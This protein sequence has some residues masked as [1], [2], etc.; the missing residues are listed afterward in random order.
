MARPVVAAALC[1]AVFGVTGCGGSDETTAETAPA[2]VTAAGRHSELV[3]GGRTGRKSPANP[4][5]KG[6]SLLVQE[7]YRQ[8]P[9]PEPD[10][11]VKGAP[12]ASRAGE[13]AC[14]GKTPVEVKE[15]TFPVAVSTGSLDPES[16]EG[17]LIAKIDQFE[18]RVT[19]E[20]SF[21]AGQLAAD[22][23]K[24]TLPASLAAAGYEGCVYALAQELERRLS[25]GG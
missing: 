19:K 10:P 15:A 21:T 8:F 22:S 5:P 11:A 3:G 24:A 13:R 17:K 7:L 1:A 25:A 14:E 6:S 18:S 23:Y 20:P 2:P 9:P 12:A 4:A 16:A